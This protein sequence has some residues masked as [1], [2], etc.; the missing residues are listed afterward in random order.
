MKSDIPKE[1]IEFQ[2]DAIQIR[3]ERMPLWARWSVWTIFAFF[4]AALLWAT[5]ARVDVIV[6]ASGKLVSDKQNLVVKP[7]DTSIIEKVHVNIG[8]IVKKNQVLITF[9]PTINNAEIARLNSEIQVLGAQFDRLSAEFRNREYVP[10]PEHGVAGQWQ[11]AIY[12]Q[13]KQYYDERINYFNSAVSQLDASRKSKEDSLSKQKERLD[14]VWKMEHMYEN[15]REKNAASLKDLWNISI[16]RMEME[17]SVDSLQNSLLEL[18]HQRESTVASRNSFIQEWRNSVS[19]EMVKVERELTTNQ[20][21]LEKN[22]QLVSYVYLRAPCEAMVH[23]ITALSVGSAIREG[24]PIMTLIPLDG[25]IEMEAEIRP[26]DISKVRLH[27]DARIKLDA[28]PFQK[29][30]TMKGKVRNI[31][32]DTLIRREQP[33]ADHPNQSY[34]RALISVAGQLRNQ[35]PN[36]RLVPGMEAQAEI[37]VGRRRVIEYIVHPLIKMFD[38]AAREP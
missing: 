24:D 27:A 33:T 21:T 19:E 35:P 25:K 2:P 14:V 29:Y 12:D 1:A 9:D 3:D 32:Q 13:R 34:Y 30:G 7:L 22:R 18:A 6:Q 10:K 17:G 23:E 5:F 4:V 31:S 37:K 16:T 8:D 28:Y 15:L 11:R 36:F 38:E 26:Q 20:K